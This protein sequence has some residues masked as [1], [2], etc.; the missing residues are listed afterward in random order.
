M[1]TFLLMAIGGLNWGL[2]GIGGWNV[3]E[4]LLGAWPMLV[5]AV[6]IIVGLATVY[7]LVSHKANCKMCSMK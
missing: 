1:V 2:V 6:Y 5:S 3:V 7:E 4:M